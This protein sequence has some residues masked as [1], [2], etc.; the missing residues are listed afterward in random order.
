MQ[1]AQLTAAL[2]AAEKQITLRLSRDKSF[3]VSGNRAGALLQIL[4]PRVGSPH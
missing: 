2:P 3:P 4:T 1:T